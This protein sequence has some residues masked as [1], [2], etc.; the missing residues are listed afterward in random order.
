MGTGSI[1]QISKLH[2]L[3]TWKSALVDSIMVDLSLIELQQVAG[4]PAKGS[5]NAERLRCESSRGLLANEN[6]TFFAQ[7]KLKLSFAM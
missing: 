2:S 4:I 6:K 7:F 1:G 5:W 3:L